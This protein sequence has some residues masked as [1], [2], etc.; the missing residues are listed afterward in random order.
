M[1]NE[2]QQIVFLHSY[3]DQNKD[4]RLDY[5]EYANLM[6]SKGMTISDAEVKY[7]FDMADKNEDG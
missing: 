2:V 6:R 7:L 1:I 4:G 5:K 3:A